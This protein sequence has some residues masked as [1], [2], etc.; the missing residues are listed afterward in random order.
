MD[1]IPSAPSSSGHVF[2]NGS[3]ARLTATSSRLT[4]ISA[5]SPNRFTARA[6]GPPCTNAPTTPQKV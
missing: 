6:S 3:A 5:G 2:T 1:S 4:A